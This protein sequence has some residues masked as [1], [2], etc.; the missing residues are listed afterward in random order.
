MP[1][2]PANRFPM[3]LL[4]LDG[5]GERPDSDDN[6]VR[7][8]RPAAMQSLARAWPSTLIEA[9]GEVVG[10]PPGIM[11]NSEAGHLCIGAGRTVFQDMSR[12][13]RAIRDGTF[14]RNP[15]LNQAFEACA[16]SGGALHLMGLVSDGGVHSHIEHLHA[17]LGMAKGAGM[18]DIRVHAFTDGRDTPP[19]SGGGY[20]RD[21]GRFLDETG[22]GRIVTVSGRYYAMD[23]DKRWD[24]TELA[25]DTMTRPE[26]ERCDTAPAY[27][28]A[29]YRDGTT[30][31]FLP[32]IAIGTVAEVSETRIHHGD[33]II[34]FNFRADRARQLTRVFTEEGFSGFEPKIRPR[35]SRYTCFTVYDKTF[36]LPAAF[37]RELPTGVFA[38][39]I[40]HNG[41][42][43][44]HIA[45]TEKY[46]HVTFFLNGGIEKP[47]SG[48]ERILIPSPRVA[49]YDQMPEMSA[50]GITAEVLKRL[51][52]DPAE[53]LVV[54][55]ANADM[56]GHTGVYEA[57]VRACRTVDG[58]V[59]RIVRAVLAR[60]GLACVTSDHGNAEQ[61]YDRANRQPH[62]AHTTSRVPIILAGEAVRGRNLRDGG[63]LPDIIPTL[64]DLLELDRPDGMSG[65]S[66]LR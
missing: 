57:A 66:L 12:I 61:M 4:I 2:A 64:F 38:D 36:T 24:R 6:A 55:F 7:N 35:L 9:S 17:L 45:E 18:R 62:T 1:T 23:R 16:G 34:F 52:G 20:L 13:S 44:L 28:E 53:I 25:Y 65:R 50:A 51:Q 54:N 10:L 63:G 60:G 15:V 8:S 11:G 59:E 26:S 49:T 37:P 43:Q 42:R 40:A 3:V 22:A 30:D 32:P 41:W 29:M 39:V 47:F 48:E 14:T 5:W 33:A 46:A 27:A 58:C 19:E 56:V 31:E 21:L